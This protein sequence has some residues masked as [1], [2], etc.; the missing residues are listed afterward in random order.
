[1]P[2]ISA[3]TAFV[4]IL[5]NMAKFRAAM[6]TGLA[7]V[8]KSTKAAGR[9]LTHHVTLPIVAAGA[10][11]IKLAYDFDRTFEMMVG[12]AGVAGKE[13]DGLKEKVLDMASQVGKSPLE[14]AKALYFIRSAGL[15]G[16]NAMNTLRASAK[17]STAGLGDTEVVADALTSA[18][19]AYGA[20]TLNA[21]QAGDILAATVRE[22]K[23]EA[24][25]IAPVLG[26]LLPLSQRLGVSFDQVGASIAAMTRIGESAPRAATALRGLYTSLLN[27][28]P[29]VTGAL[30][31][32]GLSVGDLQ[33]HL[34]DPSKGLPFVLTELEDAF[35]GNI[36]KIREAFPNIRGLSGLLEL[37][38]KNGKATQAIFKRLEKSGGTMNKAFKEVTEGEGFKFE[39]LM[40]NLRVAGIRLGNVLLPVVANIAERLTHWIKA[41]QKLSP[42]TKKFILIAVGVAAVLGPAL[43]LISG[44]ATAIGLLISPVGLVI[45]AIAALVAGFVLLYRHSEQVQKAVGDMWK[46]IQDTA[47]RAIRWYEGTLK[48]AIDNVL[49]AITALWK[50]YGGAITNIVMTQLRFILQIVK[51]VFNIIKGFVEFF[52]AVLRGDWSAAWGALKTIVSNQL[53]LAKD[54]VV[55]MVTQFLNAAKL[56]GRAIWDGIKAGLGALWGKIKDIFSSVGASIASFATGTALDWGK[57]IGSAIVDGIITGMAGLPGRIAGAIRGAL[58]DPGGGVPFVPGLAAGG[59]ASAGRLHIVGERGPELFVPRRHG[60]VIPNHLLAALGGKSDN[61]RIHGTLD[62][63]DGLVGVVDGVLS[64]DAG[65]KRQVGRMR[66]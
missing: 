4:D 6:A 10:A 29:K 38:G 51:R 49:A 17:L 28:S 56:V 23:G 25:A 14:L 30:K 15:A 65:H 63:G 44:I 20:E 46:W 18:I 45:L 41:F 47:Q 9:S 24:D 34:A 59:A 31:D 19:N 50:R 32:V 36:Q 40:A 1:M 42:Q 21:A 61:M 55:H 13:V 43:L 60:T 57:D 54:V 7:G 48:P 53:G 58:P 39:K 3:G 35:G 11:S 66:R 27:Q 8:A 12:L 2:G 33:D 5:P 26:S 37:T 62:L 22:G 52:L 64:E 16:A